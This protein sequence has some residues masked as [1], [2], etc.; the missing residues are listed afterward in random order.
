MAKQNNCANLKNRKEIVIYTIFLLIF[1][2]LVDAYRQGPDVPLTETAEPN[3]YVHQQ[4]T[5]ESQK[6]WNLIPY[7]IKKYLLNSVKADP[8]GEISFLDISTCLKENA[9]YDTGNDIITGSGEEDNT[10]STCNR[11]TFFG[12]HFWDADDPNTAS[13]LGND[14][15]NDGLKGFGSSYRRALNLWRF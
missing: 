11:R 5:N 1:V 10:K 9:D 4:I 6:V 15:Y 14:D 3:T 7:E 8:G 2:S 13:M 12:N